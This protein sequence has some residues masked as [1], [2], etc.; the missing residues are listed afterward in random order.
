MAKKLT[1]K[2]IGFLLTHDDLVS[3]GVPEHETGEFFEYIVSMS[4]RSEFVK[5]S[6]VENL[7][8]KKNQ[9]QNE[10]EKF[11]SHLE[12]NGISYSDALE[13]MKEEAPKQTNIEQQIKILVDEAISAKMTQIQNEIKDIGDK[14]TNEIPM[15]LLGG[16]MGM[17]MQG[18]FDPSKIQPMTF[19]AAAP[20]PKKEVEKVRYER[21]ASFGE[22]DF[23]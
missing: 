8:R 22:A 21:P 5:K 6:F 12:V 16:M 10:Y 15:K 2:H 1:E 23:D 17:F 9:T 3:L 18:G 14:F 19:A 4:G 7:I 13:K 11:V 20:A